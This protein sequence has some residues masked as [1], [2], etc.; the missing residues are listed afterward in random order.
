MKSKA[1]KFKHVFS[2][3]GVR[4]LAIPNIWLKEMG[5]TINTKL[6]LEYHPYKKEILVSEDYRKISPMKLP[7][8][9]KK[10]KELVEVK[11]E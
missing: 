3:G 1:V 5:W 11:V 6:V 2:T 8:E 9:K 7:S 4:V 10:K